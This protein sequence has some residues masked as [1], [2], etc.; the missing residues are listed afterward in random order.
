MKTLLKSLIFVALFFTVQTAGAQ[1]VTTASLID[2]LTNLSKLAEFPVPGFSSVQFSSYDRRSV[3]PDKPGW[4]SNSDGF[5]GEPIPGFIKVLKQPDSKGIGEYL[6][7]DVEGPGAIVRLWTAQ[8]AGDLMVWLDQEKEPIYNGLAEPFFLHT[9]EAFLKENPRAE[10]TGSL[11]QN[12]AAYYPIPFSKGCRMVWK[13]DLKKLHFYHVQM[14]LY[15]KGARVKTFTIKDISDNLKQ[16]NT[17]AAIMKEPFKHLD[18][19]LFDAAYETVWLKPG[20]KKVVKS[21]TGG[22]A[23]KRLAVFVTARNLDKALKQ[24]VM[25]IRFDGSPWGQVHSPVGDFFGAA[26]GINPYESL[27]FTVLD[28]GRMTCRYYMPFRDSAQFIMENLG[29]QEVTLVTKVV[30]EPYTWKDGISMHFRAHWRVDHELLADPKQVFDVP[31]LLIRGKGRMVGAA[32]HLMNPTSVP[33]SYGNWWGEGDEKI[34]I[35]DNLD[36][37]FIGTG[38]ED[39][40]NYAWSSEELFDFA[41]CG[42]P[43]NDGPANRGFVTNYRW[44]ILDNIPFSKSF[45]FFMELYSHR[46]VPH[47]SYA[48]MIYAYAIPGAH[49]DHMAITKA[50]VRHLELPADWWPEADG[51]AVNSVFYQFEDILYKPLNIELV[52]DAMWSARQMVLW[53]PQSKTETL[54]VLLPAS[55]TGKFQIYMTVARTAG[56]GKME[57]LLDGKPI[58]FNGSEVVDLSTEFRSVARNIASDPQELTE[59]MHVITIKPADD[60]NRPL[61]LDFIWMKTL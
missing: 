28:N 35:D 2:E 47:F 38:S 56:G 3:S 27:P 16:L 44:H 58:K 51:S 39:Y 18:T 42:Q 14:R 60:T 15:D 24:T 23:I 48:R 7:C 22:A 55:K 1:V 33:S 6:I 9:Y 37:S 52:K 36:A 45:D 20:E 32:C 25:E 40:Y 49:D 41:Y 53:S 4:F 11:N 17:A 54:T 43:R 59:G 21:I 46:V 19:V 8:I 29:D 5:G 10:W 50:D 30:T 61:G 12:M 13:G 57:L 26:P 31:Y 34:F